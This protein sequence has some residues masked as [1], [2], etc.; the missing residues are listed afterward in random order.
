MF[1]FIHQLSTFC[2]L[3]DHFFSTCWDLWA[4]IL[5]ILKH[6][7]FVFGSSDFKWTSRQLYKY[8]SNYMLNEGVHMCTWPL[9]PEH[10]VCLC[11][12]SWG[13]NV[14]F[15]CI[16]CWR[17]LS[18]SNEVTE[19]CVLS[20]KIMNVQWRNYWLRAP[21]FQRQC[22]IYSICISQPEKDPIY[23]LKICS[24]SC[25]KRIIWVSYSKEVWYPISCEL[26]D[27]VSS[28]IY[29]SIVLSNTIHILTSFCN[30]TPTFCDHDSQ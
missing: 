10:S 13:T 23:F 27:N 24:C 14:Y 8:L 28:H 29:L 11:C 25:C 15:L 12:F 19:L 1:S 17:G 20:F 2:H 21:M 4:K 6:F 18:S 16:E 7:L 3:I 5:F 22:Y 30:R 26:T 9:W